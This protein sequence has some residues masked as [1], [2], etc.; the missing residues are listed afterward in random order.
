MWR[1]EG[2]FVH[3]SILKH[4]MMVIHKIKRF[5]QRVGIKFIKLTDPN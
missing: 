5:T 4:K 3:L 1:S 2:D